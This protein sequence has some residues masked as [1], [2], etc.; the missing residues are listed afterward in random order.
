MTNILFSAVAAAAFCLPASAGAPAAVYSFSGS[1]EI[2]SGP[3]TRK[4][5]APVELAVGEMLHTGRG[6]SCEV[7]FRD[8]TFVKMDPETDFK[9][10]SV[11]IS[12]ESRGIDI[13]ALKGRLLFMVAKL[14]S[15]RSSRVRVRTPSAV[16]AVR[17]T[18]FAMHVDGEKTAL[19]L[20]EGAVEVE[21]A[22]ENTRVEPGSEI[23]TSHRS[24]P[25]VSPLSPAMEK[26]KKRCEKLKAY[27]DGVRAKLAARENYLDEHLGVS[28]KKLEGFSG[29][30]EEKLKSRSSK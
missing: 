8:G 28:R 20:F 2:I 23:T 30:R 17:G 11:S 10:T 27:V 13:D 22:G 3:N 21:A 26:E 12:A 24:R 15:A 19:G 7:L 25:S 5:T 1:V 18:D 14:K 4:V 16:C 29:R 9:I 6:A